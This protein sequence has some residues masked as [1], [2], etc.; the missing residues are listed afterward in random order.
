MCRRKN[1][2]SEKVCDLCEDLTVGMFQSQYAKFSHHR[3]FSKTNENSFYWLFSNFLPSSSGWLITPIANFPLIISMKITSYHMAV[4]YLAIRCVCTVIR[5]LRQSAALTWTLLNL[6]N[7]AWLLCFQRVENAMGHYTL[8]AKFPL[9]FHCVLTCK[10]YVCVWQIHAQ[11]GRKGWLSFL[12]IR[13]LT[14]CHLD[15]DLEELFLKDYPECYPKS[16]KSGCLV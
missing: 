11:A 16:M 15:C 13:Y 9:A 10:K 5:C 8:T 6:C 4:M 14:L 7:S 3:C 12:I 2:S 1:W